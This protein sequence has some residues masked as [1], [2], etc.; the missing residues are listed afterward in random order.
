MYFENEKKNL[1]FVEYCSM[2]E[3]CVR[4]NPIN[5]ATDRS[6]LG[7]ARFLYGDA[8][9]E[10]AIAVQ[11]RSGAIQGVSCVVDGRTLVNLI[12]QL[13][14]FSQYLFWILVGRA[15]E[16]PLFRCCHLSAS[17]MGAFILIVS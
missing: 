11:E 13:F 6:Y 8:A 15:K 2:M 12:K 3:I 5:S 14:I 9:G 17:F 4:K 16:Y 7:N 1:K 10:V